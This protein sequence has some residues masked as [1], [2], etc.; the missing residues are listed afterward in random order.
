MNLDD[1]DFHLPDELIA[2]HP[3][4]Q[5][6]GSRL[7]ILDRCKGDL[8]DSRFPHLL[9]HLRADDVLVLNETRVV[10][11]RL[12]TRKPS[13]GGLVELLVLGR[14]P[15]EG[16]MAMAKP[17]KGLVAG[18][19]LEASSGLQLEVI[20]R[21]E[22]RLHF[23]IVGH[24][25]TGVDPTGLD[26]FFQLTGDIGQIPLPP[27][28]RRSPV[29]ADSQRYQTVFA[30]T[31][32]SIAAP[33]AGL[34]FSETL[35][36]QIQRAGVTI[37]RLLL[38]VGAGTFAPVR[39]ADP[40]QHR[41]EAEYFRLEP[42]AAERI[43]KRR[44]AGGRVV[45]VGTTSVRALETCA[46]TGTLKS[47]EGWTDLVITP[48]HRFKLVDAMI[49]NFHLPRS[50][51]M[52]LVSAFAGSEHIRKAYQHAVGARYRFYSYGDAMFIHGDRR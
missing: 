20:D 52:M 9:S 48:D 34:H 51:L 40:R 31:N 7:L 32:G 28:I 10:P 44:A 45:A 26:T 11:V 8:T 16:W 25:D 46:K 2:L 36:G 19:I 30:R 21:V 17:L 5:R 23:R 37:E 41:V 43:M 35:L 12:L 42:E 22:D 6:D 49:T 14:A 24:D 18:K 15:G 4:S 39:A 38:H 3:T 47:E 1:L 29:E 50:S 33:T 13:T 27:Y